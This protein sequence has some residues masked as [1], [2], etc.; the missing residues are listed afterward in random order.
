MAVRAVTRNFGMS[1]KKVRR[2]LG[3]IRGKPVKDALATL[4][5]IPSPAAKAVAKTLQS[6]VANAENNQM[7]AAD[8]LRVVAV[9]ADDGLKLKRFRPQSRGRSSPILRRSS[10]ITVVVDEEGSEGGA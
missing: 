3:L 10:H 2:V 1:P 9:Y 6:A 5:F 7:M 8:E 4:R